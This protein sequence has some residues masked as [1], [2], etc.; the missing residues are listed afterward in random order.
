MGY[1]DGD[2]P[3]KPEHLI[4]FNEL[5]HQLYNYLRGAEGN[6]SLESFLDVLFGEAKRFRIEG[7]FGWALKTS[8]SAIV[9]DETM[10]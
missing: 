3:A 1:P 2:K 6:R 5:Q 8:L 9:T 7:D 4:G 10:N